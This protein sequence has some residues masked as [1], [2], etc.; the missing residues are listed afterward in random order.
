MLDLT[1]DVTTFGLLDMTRDIST[2]AHPYTQVVPA[3]TTAVVYPQPVM[4][5]DVSILGNL[6]RDVSLM[7]LMLGRR[8]P[9]QT[10]YCPPRPTAYPCSGVNPSPEMIEGRRRYALSPE[11][12]EKLNAWEANKKATG[13]VEPRPVPCLAP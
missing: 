13:C 4:I 9:T 3:Y 1:R 11:F 5:G 6:S 10:N 7:D 8:P 12:K 2:F